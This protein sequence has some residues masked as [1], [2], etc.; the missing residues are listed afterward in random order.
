M[1]LNIDSPGPRLCSGP[2]KAAVK[3]TVA[4]VNV[5]RVVGAGPLFVTMTRAACGVGSI[6]ISK[7]T[8]LLARLMSIAKPANIA[9]M[10]AATLAMIAGQL[11]VGASSWLASAMSAAKASIPILRL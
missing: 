7:L 2:P 6:D 5:K 11:V 3:P 8:L 1:S 4:T 9:E 10:P